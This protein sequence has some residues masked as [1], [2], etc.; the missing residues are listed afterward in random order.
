[1]LKLVGSAAF[2][3]FRNLWMLEELGVEYSH[4][5]ARPR[6]PEALAVNPFGKIPALVDDT[7]EMYESV[8]INTYLGDK[9]RGVAGVPQLVPPPGTHSRG[10]YEQLCCM[11]QSELDAQ[12]LWIHRKHASDVAKFIGGINPDAV[13]VA[14][15]HAAK[16]IDVVALELSKSQGP[17][18]LGHDFSAADILCVHCM[19]WAETVGWGA[20]W[21][22]VQE[23]D[24]AGKLL[25]DYAQRCRERPAYVRAKK[26]P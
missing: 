10:R 5:P 2:R 26:L 8:A 19:N 18:L 20:R 15:K 25:A 16:T 11:L 17:Y 7:F 12:A 3:P 23:G 1:M 21:R 13:A 4:E 14:E 6:T 22:D 9:F 24:T